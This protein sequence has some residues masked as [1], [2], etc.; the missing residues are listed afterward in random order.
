MGSFTTTCHLSS[1]EILEGDEVILLPVKYTH[2]TEINMVYGT[3][4]ACTLSWLPM[5]GKYNGFGGISLNRESKN[6]CNLF[7][8]NI[9]K[10]L[11]NIESVRLEKSKRKFNFSD[12]FYLFKRE[13]FNEVQGCEFGSDVELIEKSKDENSY[14]QTNGIDTNE[15]LLSYLYNGGLLEINSSTV[16]RFGFLLIKKDVLDDVIKIQYPDLF[17]DVIDKSTTLLNSGNSTDNLFSIGE[18]RLGRDILGL[19][20]VDNYLVH[21]LSS[22]IVTTI[23]SIYLID[24]SLIKN[25]IINSI[26]SYMAYYS[27]ISRLYRDVG[28]SFYPNVRKHRDMKPIHTLNTIVNQYIEKRRSDNLEYWSEENGYDKEENERYEWDD[29]FNQK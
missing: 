28:K 23:R 13:N 16:N 27:L 2:V 18:D 11:N 10:N 6:I 14:Y 7:R 22:V 1:L 20:N 4:S 5:I 12:N 19:F 17:D 9:N 21:K 3:N 8:G 29:S 15:K 25:K 26:V 24:N